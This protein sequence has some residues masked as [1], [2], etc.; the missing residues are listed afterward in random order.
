MCSY[1]LAARYPFTKNDPCLLHKRLV[2]PVVKR[3]QD[4]SWRFRLLKKTAVAVSDGD[5]HPPLTT[6]N[7]G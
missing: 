2:F 1:A 3:D 4:F 5:D 6:L 7:W